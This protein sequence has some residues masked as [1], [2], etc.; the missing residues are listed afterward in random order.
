MEFKKGGN[1]ME[2][3]Y[4]TMK[5]VGIWNMVFGILSILAGCLTG[6]M[7]IVSGAR[8]LKKKKEILF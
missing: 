1:G 2:K 4:K 6:A 5:S 7:L 3:V 8:L